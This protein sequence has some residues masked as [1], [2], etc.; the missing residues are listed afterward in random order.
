MKSIEKNGNLNDGK[1]EEGGKSGQDS[2]ARSNA[3]CYFDDGPPPWQSLHPQKGVPCWEALFHFVNLSTAQT[4]FELD[5]QGYG[6]PNLLSPSA[7]PADKDEFRLKARHLRRLEKDLSDGL[8]RMLRSG[9]LVAKGF[10]HSS[11]L[12]APRQAIDPERWDHLELDLRNSTAVGGGS[13]IVSILIF[14]P[15]LKPKSPRASAARVSPDQLRRWYVNRVKEWQGH[16][17]HPSRAEDVAAAKAEFGQDMVTNR[18]V[19]PLRD[20]LAPD[21]WKRKTRPRNTSDVKSTKDR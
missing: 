17:R 7:S 2:S 15:N 1:S 16:V 18:Q 4:L 8:F 20:E 11:A 3:S 5:L 12:D 10:S 14:D 13:E 19:W 9:K 21:S 6:D